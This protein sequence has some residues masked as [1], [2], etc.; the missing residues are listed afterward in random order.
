MRDRKTIKSIGARLISHNLAQKP[1]LM[2]QSP[3]TITWED[4]AIDGPEMY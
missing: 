3:E 4:L 2:T 1:Q